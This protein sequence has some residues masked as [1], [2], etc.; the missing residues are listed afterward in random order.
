MMRGLRLWSS[1]ALLLARVAW[2][3][4]VVLKNGSVFEGVIVRETEEA[5]AIEGDYGTITLPRYR[6][7]EVRKGPV[8]APPVAAAGR[9]KKASPSGRNPEA[10]PA[11]RLPSP[12]A[13]LPAL[14]SAA[15]EEVAAIDAGGPVLRMVLS[16]DGGTLATVVGGKPEVRLWDLSA[17]KHRLDLKGL[18]RP[19]DGI[20]CSPSGRWLA[21]AGESEGTIR[22]WD[23]ASGL[24]QQARPHPRVAAVAFS[25]DGKRLAS[26]DRNGLVHLWDDWNP[27][28]L[29]VL[30][31]RLTSVESLAFSPDGQWLLAGGA[32]VSGTIERWRVSDAELDGTLE[33]HGQPVKALVFSEDG[34][35]LAS[36]DAGGKIR[37][38]RVRDWKEEVLL[39][40]H[41]GEVVSLA[42]SGDGRRLAS[43]GEDRIVRLWKTEGETGEIVKVFEHPGPVQGVVF[44]SD[45]KRLVSGGLDGRIRFWEIEP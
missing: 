19:A 23:L 31:G 20:A 13:K 32:G 9:E 25:S 14:P 38:W 1:V 10:P 30:D 44:S 27:L 43:A 22:V 36:A 8:S 21:A 37:L 12:P 45:G 17:R 40:A 42:F 5:V 2:A 26:G 28:P 15:P 41:R 24:E 7:G 16:R 18:A 33:G 6:I 35:S 11:D 4:A 29:A 39:A 3:D 34:G